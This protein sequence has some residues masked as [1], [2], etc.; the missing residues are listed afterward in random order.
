MQEY[1]YKQ[2]INKIFDKYLI[3]YHN[4]KI[5]IRLLWDAMKVDLLHLKINI[6]FLK[7]GLIQ[8]QCSGIFFVND[9]ID[10]NGKITQEFILRKLKN[11]SNW[12]AKFSIL[13]KAFPKNW[14]ENLKTESSVKSTGI[15]NIKK[16]YFIWSDQFINLSTLSNKLSYN[17][18]M[19]V[20]FSKPIG[21]HYWTNYLVYI[22]SFSSFFRSH[23][24]WNISKRCKIEL[25]F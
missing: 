5:D 3:Q 6:Y 17:K 21:T 22:F 15:V 10:K 16:Y 2:L 14:I 23:M 20:K 12:I 8:W 18:L 11:K 24:P 7:N 4:N 13:K 19:N 25:C 1:D 9:I